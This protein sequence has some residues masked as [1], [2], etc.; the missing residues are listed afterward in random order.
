MYEEGV[1][2]AFVRLIARNRRRYGGYIVHAGIVIIFAAFAALAFKRESDVTLSA[3][4]STT[5]VD[6]WGHSWTFTSQGVSRYDVLNRDVTAV[7]LEATRD[8]KRMGV[9]TSEKRQY[10]SGSDPNNRVPTF[11]PSTEVGI[12]GSFGQDVYVTLAGVVGQDTSEIRIT[13]NPLVRWVWLGGIC[14]AIGGLIVMWPQAERKRK[15]GGYVTT[16]RAR[17]HRG[18]DSRLTVSRREFLGAV[19]LALG[20][21]VARTARGQEETRNT[22]SGPMNQDAYHSVKLPPKTGTAAHLTVAQRDDLEHHLQC[23]CGC[24]LDVF[25]CRTTDFSCSV[26]PAMHMDVVGLIAGGYDAREILDA[27]RRVYG[28]RVLMAPVKE[29][30]NWLGYILPFAAMGTGAVVVFA[31]VR[32]WSARAVA[33][34]VRDMTVDATPDELRRLRDAMRDDG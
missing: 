12:L 2:V 14:M 29:G 32:R 26:S 11:Q 7:A 10:F 19:G 21:G 20:A 5:L 28:E 3:G 34:P 4:D 22:M 31:L 9:I 17:A 16:L 25:T 1:P 6:S 18:G 13:F 24:T 27:F 30:F 33:A 15:Q 8:G 23:Q